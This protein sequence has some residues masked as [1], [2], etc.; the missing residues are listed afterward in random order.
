MGYLMINGNNTDSINECKVITLTDAYTPAND[1]RP[2]T[3]AKLQQQKKK[4][5]GLLVLLI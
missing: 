4:K 5:A 1:L 2:G 3:I